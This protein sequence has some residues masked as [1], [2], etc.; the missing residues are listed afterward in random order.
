MSDEWWVM[1]VNYW[2]CVCMFVT[3]AVVNYVYVAV[4]YNY[5]VYTSS[6]KN[7][8]YTW[9]STNNDFIRISSSSNLKSQCLHKTIVTTTARK[10]VIVAINQTF[11]NVL[12]CFEYKVK[13]IMFQFEK[14]LHK[15]LNI[16]LHLCIKL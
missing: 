14:I 3:C 2:A 7:S 11:K 13:F 5:Y 1:W 6:F 4:S 15:K 8:V 9:L 10:G 16:N 12:F